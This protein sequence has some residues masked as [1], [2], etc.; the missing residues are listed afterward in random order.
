MKVK[1]LIEKLS[2]CNG[3]LDVVIEPD[4]AEEDSVYIGPSQCL[5]IIENQLQPILLRK[6]FVEIERF[7]DE[8]DY[9]ITDNQP[10]LNCLAKEV[11]VLSSEYFAQGRGE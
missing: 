9:W 1:E 2:K 3:E 8:V 5:D 10:T 4:I 11:L 6:A 7:E